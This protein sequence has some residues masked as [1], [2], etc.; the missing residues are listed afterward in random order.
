M[1][2]FI[3]NA[4]LFW[5]ITVILFIGNIHDCRYNNIEL[6]IRQKRVADNRFPGIQYLIFGLCDS[7]Y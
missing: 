7:T 6:H 5:F 3:I 1:F 2:V 4:S